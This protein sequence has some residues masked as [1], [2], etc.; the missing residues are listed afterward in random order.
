MSLS[1]SA[2]ID[3]RIGRFADDRQDRPLD[4][5]GDG[6][7][8]GLRALRQG[9]GEVEAVEPALATEPLG[10]A[11]EDLA[12]DDARVAAGA[13][14][15]PEADGG[16]D[17]LGRLTGRALGLLERGLDGR[18]HVRAGVAVRDRIDVE[19]VDLV[20]VRLEVR[21][22]RAEGAEQALAV[23]RAADHQATSVPLSARSRG[24]IAPGS[25]ADG[26]R[27]RPARPEPEA[28]DVDGHPADLAT[29]RVADR[30]ADG[31]IDLAGDLRDGHAERD[32]QVEVD[33]DRVAE[34]DRDARL[35]ESEP[36]EQPLVR[37]RREPGHAVRS[38]RRACGRGR[39]RPGG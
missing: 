14:Q 21:D 27:W 28:V 26:R 9:V 13:H 39:S 37:A 15:R 18:E 6:A 17:P 32:G 24:P 12:G 7:V 19:R 4:R 10:H 3:R 33:V 16:G 5:L 36:L 31:R 22:R 8:G 2:A 30:V 35:G 20:D 11:A 34:A 23:A 25:G 38:E 1:R 29:E